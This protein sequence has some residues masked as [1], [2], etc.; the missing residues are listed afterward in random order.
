MQDRAVTE[1]AVPVAPA[2]SALLETQHLAVRNGHIPVHLL[3]NRNQINQSPILSVYTKELHSTVMLVLWERRKD[4]IFL[5]II[6]YT[7]LVEIVVLTMFQ[8]KP[9]SRL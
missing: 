4:G 8:C 6:F 3:N 9:K 2:C 5:W 1:V 7:V